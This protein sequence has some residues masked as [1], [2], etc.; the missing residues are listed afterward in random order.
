LLTV[1]NG[2]HL[3]YYDIF[4]EASRYRMLQGMNFSTIADH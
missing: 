4:E 1:I 3:V 2:K